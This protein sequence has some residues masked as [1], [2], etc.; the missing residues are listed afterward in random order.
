MCLKLTSAHRKNIFLCLLILNF[1]I[2]AAHGQQLKMSDF[3]LFGGT[4]NCPTA[5]QAVPPSPGCAV[6]LGSSTTIQGGSIG[7]YK[8]IKSTGSSTIDANLYSNGT[9]E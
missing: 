9:I 7:S 5:P 6:V 3:V 8:L 1:L 4:G 2:N